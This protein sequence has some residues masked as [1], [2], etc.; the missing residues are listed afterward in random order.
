MKQPL[1]RL[2]KT[3]KMML[4][5]RSLKIF[6]SFIF[7]LLLIS[8]SSTPKPPIATVSLNV[9]PNINPLSTTT[10][11]TKALE[12][13]PVVI[14]L[15]ELTSLSTFNSADFFSLSNDYK[16][17]LANELI[18]SEEFRLIP[19]QKQKFNRTLNID[20]RFVGVVAAYKNLEQSQWRDSAII[21]P[22]ESAPEIYIFLEGNKIQIGVKP[23]CGFFCQSPKAPPGTLYEVIE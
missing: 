16:N 3:L 22:K 17:A 15:Y 19:G 1:P 20:T 12:A 6:A 21:S 10:D 7:F 13:R 9:Q 14:R 18:T 23:E 2:D 4:K 11:E 5:L 8:C